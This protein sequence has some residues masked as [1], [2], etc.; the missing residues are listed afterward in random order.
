MKVKELIKELKELDQEK[1]I[2]IGT[3]DYELGEVE[4]EIEGIMIK[5]IFPDD[6]ENYVIYDESYV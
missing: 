4:S 1:E 5:P 6:K 2:L 3:G